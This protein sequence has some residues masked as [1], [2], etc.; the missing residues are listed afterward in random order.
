MWKKH[1]ET[2]VCSVPQVQ[3]LQDEM[4]RMRFTK[5]D[6]RNHA[7]GVG[8][9]IPQEEIEG[10]LAKRE[11]LLHQHAIGSSGV[12]WFSLK[13]KL[14]TPGLFSPESC[15]VL[16]VL[17]PLVQGSASEEEHAETMSEAVTTHA[18]PKPI[19]PNS[20]MDSAGTGR[21]DP[22]T[23]DMLKALHG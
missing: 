19:D 6:L 2:C 20:A 1:E 17:L 15:D 14:S 8:S 4:D 7:N 9:D 3:H 18:G 16:F 21:S 5:E 10:D 23:A 11:L 13:L 22:A 12:R